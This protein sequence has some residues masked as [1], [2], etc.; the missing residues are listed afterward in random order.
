[1]R[2][3]TARISSSCAVDSTEALLQELIL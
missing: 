2:L 1:L 3:F